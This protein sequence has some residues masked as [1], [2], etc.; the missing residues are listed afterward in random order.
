MP[1]IIM[2]NLQD[3]YRSLEARFG[4]RVESG[5]CAAEL[6]LKKNK[7]MPSEVMFLDARLRSRGNLF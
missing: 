6:Y 2:I 7:W 4:S 1:T 5:N 3:R